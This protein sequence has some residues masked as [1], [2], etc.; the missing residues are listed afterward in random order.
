MLVKRPCRLS[1]LVDSALPGS[2]LEAW[3]FS[4]PVSFPASGPRATSRTIQT[5]RTTHLLRRPQGMAVSRAMFMLCIPPCNAIHRECTD[6]LR[7]A[8]Q[9]LSSGAG[10]RGP[11][12]VSV[13]ELYELL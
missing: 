11:G 8:V 1:T 3:L 6:H 4:A 9:A 13:G 7:A 2:Q 12:G 5:A 10:Q